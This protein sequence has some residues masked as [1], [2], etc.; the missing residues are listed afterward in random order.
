MNQLSLWATL[1]SV[2]ESKTIKP[3]YKLPHVIF[4]IMRIGTTPQ[5][6]GRY[7]IK[8]EMGLGEGSTKTLLNRLANLSLISPES[9]H[10]MGHVLTEAGKKLYDE[11]TAV[12]PYPQ[13]IDNTTNQFVLGTEAYY[14]CL[15]HQTL[16]PAVTLGIEQRDEAI[17]IGGT[18]ATVLIF[19]GEFFVFPK[20]QS[21]IPIP[22]PLKNLQKGDLII[23]GG[24]NTKHQAILSTIAAA[25]SVIKS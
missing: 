5:G 21:A 19:N 10:Q 7:K 17:K 16:N 22:V 11:L 18:G 23:I 8:D 15:K 25:L 13:P 12:I 14:V 3:S 6:I 20:E 1:R 24:G 2:F 4:T 9:K